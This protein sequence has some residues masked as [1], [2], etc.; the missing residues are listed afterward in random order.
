MSTSAAA[1]AEPTPISKLATMQAVVAGKIQ[2][3]RAHEGR[4][5]TTILSPAQD[6]YSSPSVVEV[7]S[8]RRIGQTGELVR[9]TVKISG[10]LG[11]P[12]ATVDKDTGERR[13][14]RQC[15]IMLDYV[16]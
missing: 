10:F 14:V 8:D 13:Q 3:T 11:R 16:E 2:E 7:R 12:F 15:R 6:E 1:K 4:I 9:C 5:Y